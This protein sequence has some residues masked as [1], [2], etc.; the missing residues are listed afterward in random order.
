MENEDSMVKFKT[1]YGWKTA[2]KYKVPLEYA[3][4]ADKCFPE[5]PTYGK[6][7]VIQE[8]DSVIKERDVEEFYSVLR[9][10]MMEGVMVGKSDPA[11]RI[12]AKKDG[13]EIRAIEE[14][15]D[16]LLKV[17][18]LGIHKYCNPHY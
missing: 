4:P 9:D 15:M 12:L 1:L 14:P 13:I 8:Y 3:I 16:R 2:R 10:L 18:V 6:P 7:R 17:R 5:T 11:A